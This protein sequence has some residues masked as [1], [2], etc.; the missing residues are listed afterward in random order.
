LQPTARGGLSQLAERAAAETRTLRQRLEGHDLNMAK[1][2]QSQTP[3]PANL[4][5]E[6][7]RA[8]IPV[9]ERRLAELEALNPAAIARRGDERFKEVELKVEDTLVTV[10]GNDTVEYRQFHVGSLDKAPVYMGRQVPLPEVREGYARGKQRAITNL[11]TV[12]SLFREK[13]EGLG[14]TPAGRALRA[15]GDL[16]LHPEIERA[17]GEL[18]RNAHY[19]NAIE[20]ACKALDGLVKFRSGRFDLSGTDLMTRVFSARTPVLKFNDGAAESDR[21]EQQGM[22]QLFAG[23]MQAFRNP[24]AHQII[25]DHPEKALE[26]LSFLSFLAKAVDAAK[27]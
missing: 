18:F 19:A 17:A 20:D 22:M 16:D 25:K 5:A 27:K 23:A 6:Q 3:Q 11:Q 26:I 12:V 13:L 9:L 15:I 1:R 24:R 8:A 21:S 2:P 10:F 7:M 14:E 4:N